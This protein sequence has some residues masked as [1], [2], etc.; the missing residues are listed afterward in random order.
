MDVLEPAKTT[1]IEQ[2]KAAGR[3]AGRAEGLA[4]ARAEARAEGAVAMLVSMA[5]Q[6]FGE[7]AATTMADLLELGTSEA[8]LEEIGT[9]LLTCENGD[10]LIAK[11]RQI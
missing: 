8:A 10:A 5:R 1:W 9:Y 4:E 6:R 11:I 3:A 7:A 2:A